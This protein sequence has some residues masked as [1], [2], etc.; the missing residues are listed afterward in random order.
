MTSSELS[1]G[2]RRGKGSGRRSERS[3]TGAPAEASDVLANISLRDVANTAKTAFAIAKEAISMLNVEEKMFRKDVFLQTPLQTGAMGASQTP[4]TS[5]GL[6]DQP[7]QGVALNQRTGDSIECKDMDV[8]W[9]LNPSNGGAVSTKPSWVRLVVIQ[10][11][12]FNGGNTPGYT[13]MSAASLQPYLLQLYSNASGGAVGAGGGAQGPMA[14][15]LSGILYDFQPR[16]RLLMDEYVLIDP[17]VENKA[18][19]IERKLRHRAK[20]T[21]SP[22]STVSSTIATEA[23]FQ[24]IDP[25]IGLFPTGA[26]AACAVSFSSELKF[27]DN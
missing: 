23:M 13:T 25:T 26:G 16:F 20:I 12:E 1:D 7:A 11:T 14:C 9:C 19:I 8:K 21:F 24:M 27:I 5:L 18:K 17:V 15:F 6:L 3:S 2:K 4:W 22:G 10:D